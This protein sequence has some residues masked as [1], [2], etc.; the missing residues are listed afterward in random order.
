MQSIILILT[1][2]IAEFYPR[3]VALM[4]ILVVRPWG[5][6]IVIKFVDG[7][8]VIREFPALD[9]TLIFDLSVLSKDTSS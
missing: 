4:F 6:E 1:F 2:L 5:Y 9:N 7:E 3:V 8:M